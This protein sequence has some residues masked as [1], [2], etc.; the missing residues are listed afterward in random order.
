MKTIKHVSVIE[1]QL[2]GGIWSLEAMSLLEPSAALR[3]WQNARPKSGYAEAKLTSQG[4]LV[5]EPA[6]FPT[7]RVRTIP[8]LAL[9]KRLL[10]LGGLRRLFAR[11]LRP[12]TL[13]GSSS[14]GTVATVL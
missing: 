6:S 4:E 1:R 12:S 10:G 7:V 11:V 5:L 13:A 14:G 8:V 3:A 2:P 9:R